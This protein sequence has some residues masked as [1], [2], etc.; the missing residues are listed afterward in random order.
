MANKR[1]IEAMREKRRIGARHKDLSA[2]GWHEL[3]R[4]ARSLDIDV[5]GVKRDEIEA[6]IKEVSNG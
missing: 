4:Y 6:K 1:Y 5:H 3:R 2:M